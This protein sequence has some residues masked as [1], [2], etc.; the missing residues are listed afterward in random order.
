[1]DT[2]TAT[3]GNGGAQAAPVEEVRSLVEQIL[4]EHDAKARAERSALDLIARAP[5]I[6]L[7]AKDLAPTGLLPAWIKTEGQALAVIMKGAELGIPPMAALGGIHMVEGRVGLSAEL[8]LAVALRGG[9]RHKWIE[10]TDKIATI[11]LTRPGHDPLRL[12]WTIEMAKRAGLANN[13][14]RPTWTRHPEAMLR[15]RATAAALRAYAPDLLAGLATEDELDEIREE[16]AAEA[17]ASAP[18]TL[19]DVAA[20]VAAVVQPAPVELISQ[21]VEALCVAIDEVTTEEGLAALKRTANGLRPKLGANDRKALKEAFDGAVERMRKAPTGAS[22][23]IDPAT[24]EVKSSLER[25][26]GEEG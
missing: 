6:K 23:S 3:R 16:R 2:R 18:R 7:L 11:E 20:K 9:V 1:M 13:E 25:E 14:K 26:P 5:E 10:T 19:A 12:T 22:E 8:A 4:E 21:E 17:A 24:G 15:A